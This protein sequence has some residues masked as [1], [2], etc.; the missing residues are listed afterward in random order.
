MGLRIA[1]A[2]TGLVGG[3]A[4]I[5]ALIFDRASGGG[6]VVD[7]LTWAGLILLGIATLGA[8]A[9]LVS[10]SAVWLRV[11]VAVC[12]AA[13]VGS[14]VELLTESYD[15]LVV[16]AGFGAVAVVASAVA[17]ARSERTAGGHVEAHRPGGTHAR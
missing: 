2:L 11:L 4:L 1:V 14:V 7:A 9:S 10:R 16:Y 13:L 6:V 15:D 12:F 3:L 5:T 17:L 8:G